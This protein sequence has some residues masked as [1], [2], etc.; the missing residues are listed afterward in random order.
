MKKDFR[1]LLFYPNNMNAGIVPSNLALLSAYLKNS[2]F[3]VKLFDTSLYKSLISLD[4]I[5]SKLGHVKKTDIDNY[6]TYKDKKYMYDDFV[7]IVNNYKPNLIGITLV[8]STINFSL[9]FIKLIKEKNIPVVAGGVGTTFLYERILNTGLVNYACIG[10]GEEALVELAEKLYKNEDTTKIKNIYQK[11]NG[12]IIKNPLRKLV[13]I[14][15]LLIP[16]FSI[17]DD[18]RFYRPFMGKVVRMAQM[19]LDRGCPWVCTYCA[20]PSLRKKFN[21]HKCGPYYRFKSLDK[22]F[23]EIKFMI[24]E[25]NLNFVWLSSET[26]LALKIEKFREFAERY[27][28]EINLPF[29]CQSRLDTF[30]E[31]KTRLLS[32]MGCKNISVGLEHGDEKIRNELLNKRITD[33]QVLDAIKLIKKYNIFPTLNSMIGLPDESRKDIFKTINLN[34]KISKMLKGFHNINVFIFHPFSGTKLREISIEKGY[35]KE[36]QE[37]PFSFYEESTLTMP[38]LSKEEIKG[39]ERTVLLYIKLPKYYWKKIKRAEKFDDEGNQIF[40]ELIKISKKT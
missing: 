34:R 4:D 29:W 3:Q 14:D 21:E 9:E 20:S 7:E 40:E 24:K 25:Y 27:K 30:S 26:L 10:E 22:I 37:I 12:K 38:L 32:E 15:D 5:R 39:L 35:F 33:K 36:N 1:I 28:K 23:D 18:T 19:D 11:K 6:I 2:G 13:K 31:E 16:D 17:Y 8:D